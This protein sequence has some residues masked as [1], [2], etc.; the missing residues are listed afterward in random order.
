[1]RPI[2][3]TGLQTGPIALGCVTF[4]REIDEESSFRLLDSAVE[5]GITLLDTAEAYGGGQARQYRARTLGVADEREASGEMHSS[6]KILGR[7]LRRTGA[8]EQVILQTKVSTGFA[9]EAVRRALAGSLERLGVERVDLYLF[10]SVPDGTLLEEALGVLQEAISAG[11]VGAIGASNLSADMLGES[12][13]LSA[14][15][16]LPRFEVV[17]PPYS[18]LARGIEDSLLPLCVREEIAVIPYSPLAA[19][20]LTGKYRDRVVPPGSR[21]DVIPGHQDLYFTEEN[22]A[23]VEELQRVAAADGVSLAHYALRW[24]LRNRELTSVLIGARTIEQVEQA[25]R[26]AGS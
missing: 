18:L 21:F 14:R 25:L 4:G 6:E 26:A 1:M 9:G 24:V 3:R 2:G 10:H 8:R 16:G 19:G 5:R 7:W 20:F 22:F 11:Q 15:T 23:R 17:Q 13:A 12:L